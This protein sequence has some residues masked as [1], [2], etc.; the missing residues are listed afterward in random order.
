MELEWL[1]AEVRPQGST[2]TLVGNEAGECHHCAV[3]L[4][5]VV[6]HV[7]NEPVNVIQAGTLGRMEAAVQV[8]GEGADG[9]D[10]GAAAVAIRAVGAGENAWALVSS[11]HVRADVQRSDGVGAK[12]NLESESSEEEQ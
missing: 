2:L 8:H 4:V 6:E 12:R 3:V 10:Y 7:A 9:A 11:A 1:L 5:E